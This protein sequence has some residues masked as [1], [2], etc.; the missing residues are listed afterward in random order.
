MIQSPDGLPNRISQLF[1]PVFSGIFGELFERVSPHGYLCQLMDNASLRY[2][3][4]LPDCANI[5]LAL[6]FTEVLAGRG[7]FV[8]SVSEREIG[9]F[10][11]PVPKWLYYKSFCH[12][13]DQIK[14][15]NRGK[16]R[17]KWGFAWSCPHGRE[18]CG[19]NKSVPKRTSD[20]KAPRKCRRTNHGP[21]VTT[22]PVQNQSE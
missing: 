15:V 6:S 9:D 4:P 11:Q 8:T 2:L 19:T 3:P 20:R 22:P 21:K 18:R 12:Y 17:A 14:G 13:L 1:V 10:T 16:F 5:S 7:K